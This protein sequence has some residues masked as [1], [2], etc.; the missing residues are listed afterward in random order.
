MN[1]IVRKSSLSCT[2]QNR[3]LKT[4]WLLDQP[5][6]AEA[7]GKYYCCLCCIDS[8]LHFKSIRESCRRSGIKFQKRTFLKS[9][10]KSVGKNNDVSQILYTEVSL[11]CK[12][13]EISVF[14]NK[15]TSTSFNEEHC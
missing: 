3:D 4:L 8:C 9:Q 11:N 5:N 7:N 12:K 13:K 2:I 6:Q 1:A 14:F 10:Q 15:E